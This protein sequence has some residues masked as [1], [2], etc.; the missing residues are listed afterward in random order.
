MFQL[1]FVIN[2]QDIVDKIKLANKRTVLQFLQ[3]AVPYDS[4]DNEN[5][6]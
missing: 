6:A 4:T 3:I 5:L 2:S 1:I